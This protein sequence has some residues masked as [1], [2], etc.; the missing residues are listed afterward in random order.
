MLHNLLLFKEKLFFVGESVLKSQPSI[1]KHERIILRS[2]N[3]F[4]L[5]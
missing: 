3:P 2:L 4:I 1:C 5:L